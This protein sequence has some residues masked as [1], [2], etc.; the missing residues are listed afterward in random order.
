MIYYLPIKCRK[1][2]EQVT[3]TANRPTRNTTYAT[4][5]TELSQQ[6]ESQQNEFKTRLIQPP[7]SRHRHR[8]HCNTPL[9][10]IWQISVC[11]IYETI[12]NEGLN[13]KCYKILKILKML[14]FDIFNIT[15]SGPYIVSLEYFHSPQLVKN[16]CYRWITSVSILYIL[17]KQNRQYF[18]TLVGV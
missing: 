8:M 13:M 12:C 4:S 9:I 7:L 18:F 11:A 17:I 2:W 16:P 6:N 1:T 14:V 3:L 10:I 15:F 5:A